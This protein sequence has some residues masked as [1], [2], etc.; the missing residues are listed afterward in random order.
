MK[1]LHRKMAQ[2]S[3]AYN[4]AREAELKPLPE[5]RRAA[6]TFILAGAALIVGILTVLAAIL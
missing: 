2:R 6:W 5:H 3:V 1:G 4:E